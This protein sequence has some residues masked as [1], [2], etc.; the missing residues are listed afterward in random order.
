MPDTLH[1]SDIDVLQPHRRAI[2]QPARIV[3]VADKVQRRRK[4]TSRTAH[5]KNEKHQ[6][7]GGEDNGQP[8]PKLSPVKLLLTRHDFSNRN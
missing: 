3:H 5:Q 7:D 1:I 4:Q 2:A 6:N 8:H